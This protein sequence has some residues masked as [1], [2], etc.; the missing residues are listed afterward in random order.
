MEKAME[1]FLKRQGVSGYLVRAVQAF[2]DRF[3]ISSG[4]ETAPAMLF[5]G[6]ETLEAAIAAMLAGANL[7]LIGE[8]ATGKNV[9][10]DTLVALFARPVVNVSFHI[11]MDAAAL[12]GGDTFS[13]GEVRFRPGPVYKAAKEGGFAVLDEINMARNEALAVLHE[14]LDY[15]RILD[16]PGYGRLA[17]HEAA[18]FIGTMN[19]G[20][21]GTRELNEALA[22]RFVVLEMPSLERTRIEVILKEQEPELTEEATELFTGFFL[23]LVQKAEAG[24]ISTH[25][26]DF[27]GLLDALALMKW[28]IEARQAA[29]MGLSNKCFEKDERAI[30][31]DTIALLLPKGYRAFR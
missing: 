21:A 30:V 13:G 10:A 19:Y 17:V 6:K 4:I 29:K 27:R 12:I 26:V 23:S 15:R 7:L 18:R 1:N 14:V 5:Y 3:G 28:G 9:L 16:V 11:N 2:R 24:E 20:Y 22:S 31:E 25:A 8:K